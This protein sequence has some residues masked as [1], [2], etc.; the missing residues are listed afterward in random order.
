[1]MWITNQNRMGCCQWHIQPLPQTKKNRKNS[2]T[3][4]S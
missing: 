4:S 3:T 2:M 1:V